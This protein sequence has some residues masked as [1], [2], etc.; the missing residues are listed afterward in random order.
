MAEFVLS[1]KSQLPP[2]SLSEA[3]RRWSDIYSALSSLASRVT[4]EEQEEKKEKP[5]SPVLSRIKSLL[6]LSGGASEVLDPAGLT[7]FAQPVALT[8]DEFVAA[9]ERLGAPRSSIM[10]I[11]RAPSSLLRDVGFVGSLEDALA[12]AASRMNR[13][14]MSLSPNVIGKVW[15][16]L[17]YSPAFRKSAPTFDKAIV[18]LNPSLLREYPSTPVHELAHMGIVRTPGVEPFIKWYVDH[19]DRTPEMNRIIDLANELAVALSADI[20]EPFAEYYGLRLI[21]DP[22]AQRFPYGVRGIMEGMHEYFKRQP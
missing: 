9:L 10:S 16:P 7:T 12:E 3:K 13:S 4:S 19:I 6:K 14:T 22:R 20:E 18:G 21:G 8:H 2:P 17:R 1:K 5:G 11:Y 15:D